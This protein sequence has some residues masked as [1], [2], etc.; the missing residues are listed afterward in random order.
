MNFYKFPHALA[1][2]KYKR[3]VVSGMIH[4]IRACSIWTLIHESLEKSRK[5][6]EKN[7]YPLS[8]YEPIFKKT[9]NTIITMEREREETEEDEKEL[10]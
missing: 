7:Q 6:L 10:E 1:S 8:F 2:D 9:L 4:R 3:L 5:L